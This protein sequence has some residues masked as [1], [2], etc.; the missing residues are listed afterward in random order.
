MFCNFYELKGKDTQQKILLGGKESHFL[1]FHTNVSNFPGNC[2]SDTEKCKES[3]IFDQ[4]I[5][6]PGVLRF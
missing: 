4:Q 2:G 5:L 3:S 6:L 1:V